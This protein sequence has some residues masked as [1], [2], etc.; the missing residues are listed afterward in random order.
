M[1]G[2]FFTPAHQIDRGTLEKAPVYFFVNPV[3][4]HGP[5]LSHYTDFVISRGLAQRLHKRLCAQ[6]GEHPYIEGPIIHLGVDPAPGPG[7]V[8]T[9]YQ[10]LRKHVLGACRSLV[11]L[12]ARKVIFM[13][14]HGAPLHNMAIHAGVKYLRSHGVSAFSSLNMVLEELV[15]YRPDRYKKLEQVLFNEF[16]GKKEQVKAALQVLDLDF[17]AGLFET[18]LCMEL[19]PETVHGHEGLPNC[20]QL[21]PAPLHR[22]LL[23][24]A[25][26]LGIR[27]LSGEFQFAA[28]ALAWVKLNPFPGYTGCPALACKAAGE[29]LVEERILPLYEKAALEVLWGGQSAPRPIMDWIVYLSLGGRIFKG[30]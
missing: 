28:T 8:R 3:E 11:D 20:P 18:S 17:H 7:S 25:R 13:T 21:E 22:L 12:G 4:F 24:L 1:E 27:K 19:A 23:G 14:F 2:L 26:A 16:P 10:D 29:V 9:S 15:D 30:S 5:H 6:K